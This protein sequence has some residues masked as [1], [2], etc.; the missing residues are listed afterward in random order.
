MYIITGNFKVRWKKAHGRGKLMK[1]LT[2]VVV[3]T[4]IL[5]TF[6]L[7]RTWLEEVTTEPEQNRSPFSC[8]TYDTQGNLLKSYWSEEDQMWYLFVTS[9]QSIPDV[10]LHYTGEVIHTS[11]GI[12]HAEE[13]VITGAFSQSGDSLELQLADGRTKNVVLF[14]STLPSVHIRLGKTTLD[15]IHLDKG[16]KYQGNSIYVMDPSGVYDLTEEETVEIKGRGNSTWTLYEKRAYQIKFQK[17]TSLMGMDKAKKWV[18]MANASD[19]SMLRTKLVYDMAQNLDMAFVPNMEFVDLWI[20]GEYRGLFMVGQKVEPGDSRL[21]LNSNYGA[22]FE[23]DD[24]FYEEET[25]WFR[26]NA[27]DR[28]FVLKETVEEDGQIVTSAMNTFHSAVD[29]LMNYLYA[30]PS[31]RI[32][33]EDLSALIDIDSFAKYYLIN[34]YVLNND[35]IVTSFYWYQDGPEDVLHLGP[36]WDYDTCMGNDGRACDTYAVREHILFRYLMAAPVFCERVQQL[37]EEYEPYF[38]ALPENARKLKATVEASVEMNYKRWDVLGKPN[39]RGDQIFYPTYDEAVTTLYN[40]LEGRHAAFAVEGA[41]VANGAVSDDCSRMD[42]SFT[43]QAPYESVRFAVWNLNRQSQKVFWYDGIRDEAGNWT[44]SVDL[45]QHAAAGIY[46]INVYPDNLPEPVAMGYGYAREAMTPIYRMQTKLSA[47]EENLTVTMSDS[48]RCREVFFVV[49]S[50][51]GGQDDVQWHYASRNLK[52]EWAC[53]V[54]L[55]QHPG[56]GRYAIHAY[57]ME[58]G[59][60]VLVDYENVDFSTVETP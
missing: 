24:L 26:S 57:S 20:D 36:I 51:E 44:A 23:H 19:D 39:P 9:D 29:A 47:N 30:T 40:W 4:L 2:A 21:N 1:K 16:E 27:L 25:Y 50:E 52:G 12:L 8:S 6:L 35:A 5:I 54:P 41:V 3:I 59:Q 48:D 11:S 38:A 49:W 33:L 42:V 56:D 17:A 28:Y 15:R 43:E 34:E 18:L 31:S 22:L 10:A 32:T 46:S 58:A 60:P 55:Q 7:S 53:T 13:G 45:A 37:W 14:Q